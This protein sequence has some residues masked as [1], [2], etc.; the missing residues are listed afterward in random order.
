MPSVAFC[1][2][3]DIDPCAWLKVRRHMEAEKTLN[4]RK[5]SNL[6]DERIVIRSILDAYYVAFMVP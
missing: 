5:I 6:Q 1:V 4:T 3:C 2:S